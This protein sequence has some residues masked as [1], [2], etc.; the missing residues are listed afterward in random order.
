MWGALRDSPL[1]PLPPV[2]QLLND[3]FVVGQ[4]EGTYKVR[5]EFVGMPD[6]LQG[7]VAHPGMLGHGAGSY[8][9]LSRHYRTHVSKALIAASVGRMLDAHRR[10]LLSF[11]AGAPDWS[12]LDAPNAATL[13]AVQWRM[14]NLA[15]LDGRRR[16]EL[17]GRPGG[18]LGRIC[19][20]SSRN[21]PG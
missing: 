7:G 15:G 21:G 19:E 3:V 16:S 2:A 13:P 1:R 11:E 17:V 10:F 9:S 12:L 5:F 14:E 20:R 18:G 4:L 6:A 8:L